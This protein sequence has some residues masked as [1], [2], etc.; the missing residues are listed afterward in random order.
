MWA[1]EAPPDAVRRRV[2]ALRSDAARWRADRA[3]AERRSRIARV[4]RAAVASAAFGASGGS[5][6]APVLASLGIVSIRGIKG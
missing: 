3:E 4:G 5:L 2:A 6:L 1:L